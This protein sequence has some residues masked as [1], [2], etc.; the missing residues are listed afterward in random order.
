MIESH[1]L[2]ETIVRFE[3]NEKELD[4]LLVH[5]QS[6]QSLL[7]DILIGTHSELM[8]DDEIDYLMF[9]FLGIYGTFQKQITIPVFDEA[10][11]SKSEEES[12]KVINENND[13]NTA[14]DIFFSELKEEEVMEFID[15]SIAPDDE[16]EIK[17]S[18]PGR[19]IMLA[20]LTALSRLLENV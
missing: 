20:V 11:I 3:N 6:D 5:L 7:L 12:W 8:T 16:N 10:A 13:Y 2:D 4:K 14:L 9:L 15:L 18:D 19:L 1:H 17:I